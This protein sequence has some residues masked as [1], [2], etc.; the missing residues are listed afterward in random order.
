MVLTWCTPINLS[1][2]FS[3]SWTGMKHCCLGCAIESIGRV[4][5][6]FARER[7]PHRS[8]KIKQFHFLSASHWELSSLG[9][10]RAREVFSKVM[11]VVCVT[12]V[13]SQWPKIYG[14]L[15]WKFVGIW[16]EKYAQ[17]C[18]VV[19]CAAR[20]VRLAL[21]QTVGQHKSAG[22]GVEHH[23]GCG[24]HITGEKARLRGD[25]RNLNWFRALSAQILTR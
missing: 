21:L 11:N 25:K 6:T 7:F 16:R 4:S 14:P 19:D 23:L 22:N 20:V 12:R 15:T 24:E 3:E 1:S 17:S 13:H 10:S 5:E 9:R 8:F 18:L 2:R